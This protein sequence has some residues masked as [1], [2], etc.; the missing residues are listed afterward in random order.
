MTMT[1]IELKAL[2]IELAAAIPPAYCAACGQPADRS[3]P[4]AVAGPRTASVPDREEVADALARLVQAEC[5][6]RVLS[7][8]L[9][10]NTTGHT[11][12]QAS[13]TLDGALALL[14]GC[15]EVLSAIPLPKL[16]ASADA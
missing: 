11:E 7:S 10:E 4:A 14:S 13:E 1:P 6:L 3:R 16:P 9:T 8:W 15:H 2:A 5:T 12:W